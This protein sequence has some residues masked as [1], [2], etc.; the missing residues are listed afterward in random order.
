MLATFLD[1]LGH[2]TAA[3]R[4]QLDEPWDEM[5]LMRRFIADLYDSLLAHREALVG[6]ASAASEPDGDLL[7][8]LRPAIARILD[9]VQ[10]IGEYEAGT[11]GWF[12]PEMSARTGPLVIAMAAGVAMMQPWFFAE[13]AIGDQI[14]EDMA[15]FSLGGLGMGSVDGVD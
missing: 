3:W 1:F 15:R 10:A 7:A 9:E 12:T 4:A 5:R 14:T 8:E 2:F 13:D 11:R 6:L